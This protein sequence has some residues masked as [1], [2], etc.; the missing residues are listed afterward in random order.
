LGSGVPGYYLKEL[1]DGV[2]ATP[3]DVIK[4][5]ATVVLKPTVYNRAWFESLPA[6]QPIVWTGKVKTQGASGA[7]FAE[8][9]RMG[10]VGAFRNLHQGK[11]GRTRGECFADFKNDLAKEL[12]RVPGSSTP[13]GARAAVR[14]VRQ[15]HY[16]QAETSHDF[17]CLAVLMQRTP[18]QLWGDLEGSFQSHNLNV[19]AAPEAISLDMLLEM[20]LRGPWGDQIRQPLKGIDQATELLHEKVSERERMEAAVAAIDPTMAAILRLEVMDVETGTGDN[21]DAGMAESMYEAMDSRMDSWWI[22]NGWEDAFDDSCPNFTRDLS[23]S[24]PTTQAFTVTHGQASPEHFQGLSRARHDPAWAIPGGWRDALQKDIDLMTGKQNGRAAIEYMTEA[25]LRHCKA[26]YGALC[27]VLFIVHDC[28]IKKNMQ[29][30]VT[31]RKV[32]GCL[33]DSTKRGRAA[34][35]Y[36]ATVASSS[37]RLMAQFQALHPGANSAQNDISGAYYEGTPLHPDDGGRCLFAHVPAEFEEFGY[38]QYNEAGEKMYFEVKGNMPGRQE[39]GRIWG[40]EYTT[41]LVEVCGL[42]QSI[43]DRRLFFKIGENEEKLLVA[44]YVDDSWRIGT[45]DRIAQAFDT[46]WSSRFTLASDVADTMGDFV[47]AHI[48]QDD[49]TGAVS[50]SCERLYSDLEV[51]MSQPGCG[52]PAGFKID[53]PMAT[54][55]L[56]DFR[57]PAHEVTNPMQGDDIKE[58]ARSIVGLGGFIVCNVR[59]DAHFAFVVLCQY[60]GCRLTLNVWKGIRRWAHYLIATRELH[61]TYRKP[62]GDTEWSMHSDSSLNNVEGRAASFGGMAFGVEGSGLVD[63]QV[64]APRQISDSS[65]SAELV[66][67]TRAAKAILGFRLLLKELGMLHEGP[68]PMYLDASAVISGAEMEK[69]TREMRYMAARYAQLRQ[70]KQDGKVKLCKVDTL[71]NRADIFTKPLVGEAFRRQRCLVLGLEESGSSGA[72]RTK[73]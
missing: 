45:N 15:A 38:S 1:V 59:P 20:D 4:A 61:L 55:A 10:T 26:K 67:A 13:S 62:A 71:D 14:D 50:L 2:P 28:K 9:S 73:D 51:K 17:R 40:D 11:L 66:I 6:H 44:V 52:I 53:Y 16:L 63:W 56:A 68:T 23:G 3:L 21:V 65:A 33:A 36:S 46:N 22:Q 47:G 69:V 8:Y 24:S 30:K 57:L 42:T 72:G 49:S 12:L 7:R 34:G 70:V 25:R 60:V 54:T 18:T 5:P 37:R 39:A 41:F 58:E 31:K 35:T 64:I 32:R 29:K 27:E 19:M 43:V 48:V